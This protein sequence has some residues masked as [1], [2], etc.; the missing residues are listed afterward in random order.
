MSFFLTLEVLIPV[1]ES[2]VLLF[3]WFSDDPDPEGQGFCQAGFSVDF[4]KVKTAATAAHY[5]RDNPPSHPSHCTHLALSQS[6]SGGVS[7][8][9]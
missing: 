3:V 6:A 2:Q 7:P 1:F 8:D 5:R 4:T 9:T